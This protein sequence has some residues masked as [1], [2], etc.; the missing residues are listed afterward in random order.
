MSW[1]AGIHGY[2]AK[3]DVVTATVSRPHAPHLAR[4]ARFERDC[5]S[6][7]AATVEIWFMHRAAQVIGMGGD[8]GLQ[9]WP[10]TYGLAFAFKPP[11]TAWDLVCGIAEGRYDH[12]SAGYRMEAATTQRQAGT[13]FDSISRATLNEISICPRGA[14][15]GAV[16]WH[17]A[18]APRALP[19]HAATLLPTWQRGR[20]QGRHAA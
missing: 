16:C 7:D 11:A 18:N 10:D 8:L 19:P 17:A 9:I 3:W 15:P 1:R 12:C 6:Y 5:F 20:P 4:P 13:A 2:V 14:C